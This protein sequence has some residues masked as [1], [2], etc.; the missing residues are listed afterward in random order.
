M[1]RTPIAAVASVL[2]LVSPFLA[3]AKSAQTASGAYK[4]GVANRTFTPEGPYN[5]RGAKT[6]GLSSVVWYPASAASVE[7]A[8]WIGSPDRPLLSAGKAMKDAA[9]ASLPA[10]FPLVLLSHGT[11]GS[12]LN[13]GWL[14]T[15]L[16]SHGYIAVA[17]NHPGNNGYDGYTPLGFSTWWER[18]K[19]LSTA[20]DKMLADST[21]GGRIDPERIGAAGFSL[22][23]YT[24]IEIAGGV[25]DTAAFAEF[26]KSP[27]AD[28]ICRSPPEFP[29]LL[30]QFDRLSKTDT[31]FQE[32][33][34]HAGDSYRDPRVRAVFAMAPAL[35]PA[36][37]ARGLEKISIPVEIVSGDADENVPVASGAKYFGEHIPG[38]KLV[39]FSGGV[40]HYVFLPTC[41]KQGRATLAR[42]CQDRPGV[43][44]ESIHARTSKMAL[45]FLAANLQ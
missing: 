22:G 3:A 16:A 27:K 21:F 12:A 24:M 26:C 20:I 6:R 41:T 8:Q 14:G 30:E 37:P 28:D 19:D 23:G 33:L 29:D 1:N 39:I 7:Q 34:R 9:L 38:A 36:F 15:A 11:G 40:G 32:S 5:W 2:V 4:V 18:A 45:A 44:R 42:L 13:M 10:K 31:R 25:T 17:V 35:G 43:D